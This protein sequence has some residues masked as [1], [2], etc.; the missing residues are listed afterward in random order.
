MSEKEG[1]I[2]S[3][4]ARK[5][6]SATKQESKKAKKQGSKEARKKDQPIQ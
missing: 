4:K 2:A 1:A 5:Q 3:Q 6:E